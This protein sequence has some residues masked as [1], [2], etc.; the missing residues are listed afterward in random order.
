MR[1]LFFYRLPMATSLRQTIIWTLLLISLLTGTF[2]LY[3]LGFSGVFH[4]DDEPNLG[5]LLIANAP[6]DVWAFVTSGI[7]GPLGRPVALASFYL[8]NGADWPSLPS[9]FFHTNTL[10]HLVNGL[11]VAWLFYLIGSGNKNNNHWFSLAVMAIWLAHP[12]LVSTS[13][14]AVQRMTSLSATFVLSGLIVY[15]KSRKLVGT[16]PVASLLWMTFGVGLF[17][18]LAAFTKENGLLILGF[19]LVIEYTL[20]PAHEYPTN[21]TFRRWRM[22]FLWL[23]CLA[24]LLILLWKLPGFASSYSGRTFSLPE[25]LQTEVVVLVD[26]L[27]LI[28]IPT[29]AELGP[30]ADDYPIFSSPLSSKVILATIFWVSAVIAA[31][32]FRKTAPYF[33]FAV[34]WFLVGHS[35]E[36][37]VVPLEIYFEH[38]NYLPA[39]GVIAMI[40]VIP[41]RVPDKIFKVI[42]LGL[43]IYWLELAFVLGETTDTWGRPV[44]A[45]S[46]WHQDHPASE[47]AALFLAGE[48]AKRGDYRSAL[49]VTDETAKLI[50]YDTGLSASALLAACYLNDRPILDSRL[51]DI[52]S[53][54]RNNPPDFAAIDTLEKLMAVKEKRC[55]WLDDST[56]KQLSDAMLMNPRITT[57]RFVVARLHNINA[58]IALNDRDFIAYINELEL[59][60]VATPQISSA[61]NLLSALCREG[62]WEAASEKLALIDSRT[63]KNIFHKRLWEKR[64]MPLRQLIEHHRSRNGSPSTS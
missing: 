5:W 53:R 58:Q 33:S 10:I 49:S 45:A 31:L 24:A 62:L 61:I 52:T 40:A 22:I 50:P 9:A 54:L 47:R 14:M 6:E 51:G 28:L 19:I 15:V 43:V 1:A 37:T 48:Y 23:P 63:P 20:L 30:F 41:W 17:G 27:R 57:K 56:V 11:L 46:L 42:T 39:I 25:R 2:F 13:L 32:R 36:S 44:L 12:L 38:R 26:Y 59:S 21:S 7:A 8:L 3:S 34:L 29:R 35:M 18:L 60:F 55:R 64:L 16:R 4:F